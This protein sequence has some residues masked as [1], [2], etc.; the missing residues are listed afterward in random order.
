MTCAVLMDSVCDVCKKKKNSDSLPL[1]CF[2]KAT[3]PPDDERQDVKALLEK[4]LEEDEH[5][6]HNTEW[7]EETEIWGSQGLSF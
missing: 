6:T 3:F 4:T 5:V 1:L 7:K 2:L